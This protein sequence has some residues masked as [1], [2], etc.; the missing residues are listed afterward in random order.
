MEKELEDGEGCHLY[1]DLS[2]QRLEGVIRVS[3]S[4]KDFMLLRSTRDNL[5]QQMQVAFE[6][7]Q[8]RSGGV[9][10]LEVRSSH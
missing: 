5:R 1:G 2:V 8:K 9:G 10:D 6:R 3:V 7:L 4:M